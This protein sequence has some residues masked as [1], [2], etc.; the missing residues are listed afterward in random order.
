MAADKKSSSGDSYPRATGET[1]A[2]PKVE[3]SIWGYCHDGEK[4]E[5]E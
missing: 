3:E 4:P 2:A 5:E 1:E